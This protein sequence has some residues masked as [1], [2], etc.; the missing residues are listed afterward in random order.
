MSVQIFSF[1]SIV[2]YNIVNTFIVI[3]TLLINLF[4]KKMV[5]GS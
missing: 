3:K 2:I 5:I 4:P 1:Y